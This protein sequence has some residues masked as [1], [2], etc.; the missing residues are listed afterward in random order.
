MVLYLLTVFISQ[1]TNVDYAKLND[2]G[3]PLLGSIVGG[4]WL[5]SLLSIGGMASAIGIFSAVMLSISRIPRAMAEDKF[6]PIVLAKTHSK[7]NTPFISIII[8]ALVVS[9]MDLW[10]FKELIVIDVILYGAGLFLEYI[11]LIVLRIKEPEA[12]RPFKIPLNTFWLCVLLILPT[13]VYFIA[14]IS[15]LT[16]PDSSAT[17]AYF[18]IGGLLTAEMAW[19]LIRKRNRK[20]A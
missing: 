14:L 4:N 12:T 16:K 20:R 11:S 9:F 3:Y 1:N 15:V 18:A 6:L 7:F 17:P 19:L 8:C 13:A 10:T 2:E 5:A